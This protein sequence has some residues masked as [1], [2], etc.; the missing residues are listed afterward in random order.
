M[1]EAELHWKAST[2]YRRGVQS[3]LARLLSQILVL[4]WCVQTEGFPHSRLLCENVTENSPKLSVPILNEQG[5]VLPRRNNSA[6]LIFFSGQVTPKMQYFQ[7]LICK[8]FHG[9]DKWN[10]I[11]LSWRRSAHSLQSRLLWMLTCNCRKNTFLRKS[12]RQNITLSHEGV[13]RNIVNSR[14]RR[15]RFTGR[16]ICASNKSWDNSLNFRLP[17]QIRVNLVWFLCSNWQSIYH[18]AFTTSTN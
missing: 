8:G 14:Y 1:D 9:R 6:I 11:N 16:R 5:T 15:I 2:T 10:H 18:Q 17:A 7:V 4:G 12:W 3:A 13:R